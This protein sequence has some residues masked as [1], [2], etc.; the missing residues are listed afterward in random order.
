M[1]QAERP[2][3]VV[4]ISGRGRNLQA[5]IEAQ[6]NGRLDVDIRA[7]I[8]NRNSAAGLV[9]ARDAGI[10]TYVLKPMKNQS[11]AAYDLALAEMIDNHRPAVVVLAGFM[12]ILSS[13]FVQ[14]FSGKL[15]NIHPSLLPKYRGLDTHRRVL[16]AGDTQH[17]ASVHFVTEDLDAG[18]V[19]LQGSIA[20]ATDDTVQSLSERLIHDVET[21]IYPQAL[22][23]IA[24]G[25]ARLRNGRIEFDA[26][27]LKAPIHENCSQPQT[28]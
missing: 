16:A 12:R 2:G 3:V 11:R 24:H 20:V 1:A 13:G 5:L 21:R 26:Q 9:F 14:R 19:V 22:Q 6:K 15:I 10:P 27:P 4:L 25:R 8:S 28:I 18:P 7:V 17:G 23:W